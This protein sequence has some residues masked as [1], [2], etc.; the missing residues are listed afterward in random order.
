MNPLG[1][2]RLMATIGLAYGLLLAL[3]MIMMGSVGV[4]N[5]F[6]GTDFSMAT[7]ILQSIVSNYYMIVV[8]HLMGY[9]IFQYQDKLGFSAT[10]SD[11]EA[12]ELRP[13]RDRLAALIDVNIKEGN[14]EEVLA[15]LITAIKD[16]PNDREFFPCIWIFSSRTA[17]KTSCAAC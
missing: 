5:E 8:F 16:F 10:E 1:T 17:G 7:N 3:I 2:V 14:Y 6:I 9:M 12:A 4:I 11:G 15:Q 13:E